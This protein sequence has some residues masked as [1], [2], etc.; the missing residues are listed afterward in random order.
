MFLH[1][2]LSCFLCNELSYFYILCYRCFCFAAVSFSIKVKEEEVTSLKTRTALLYESSG[3]EDEDGSTES[4]TASL[5]SRS[6]PH[7]LSRSSL[8]STTVDKPA[9]NLEELEKKQG[10]CR[11]F[12]FV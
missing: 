12:V 9:G 2:E 10:I 6:L 11:L 7:S 4:E 1:N 5:A 3:D 8:A